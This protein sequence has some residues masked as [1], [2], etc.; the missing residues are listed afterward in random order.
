[1]ELIQIFLWS[2]VGAGQQ[3]Y[4]VQMPSTSG[5]PGGRVQQRQASSS[6]ITNGGMSRGQQ[7]NDIVQSL[8]T[9]STAQYGQSILRPEL[10]KGTQQTKVRQQPIQQQ[11]QMIIQQEDTS[12]QQLVYADIAQQMSSGETYLAVVNGVTYQIIDDSKQG[13]YIAHATSGEAGGSVL[14]FGS[15]ISLEDLA[16][17]AEQET[18]HLNYQMTEDGNVIAGTQDGG[19]EVSH[20]MMDEQQYLQQTHGGTLAT[21]A[22]GMQVLYCFLFTWYRRI[23]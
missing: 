9:G 23:G 19:G 15:G 14:P 10:V 17:C 8:L 6:R 22:D 11:Q 4:I 21:T 3:Q 1:M 7:S 5:T 2:V 13:G 16:N 20:V 12:Q 18:M